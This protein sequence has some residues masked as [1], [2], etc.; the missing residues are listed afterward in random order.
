MSAARLLEDVP[1]PLRSVGYFL[2]KA[3]RLAHDAARG[4]QQTPIGAAGGSCRR[5]AAVPASTSREGGRPLPQRH[6]QTAKASGNTVSEN[7]AV[8]RGQDRPKGFGTGC[9]SEK[10]LLAERGGRP[11]S[12]PE[13]EWRRLYL[14]GLETREAVPKAEAYYENFTR[15]PIPGL[16]GKRR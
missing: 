15:R 9:A 5:P 13:K 11:A 6:G 14:E 12:V 2:A 16:T 1:R 8:G 7:A 4:V 3:L 10:L